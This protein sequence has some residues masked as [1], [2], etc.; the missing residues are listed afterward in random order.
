VVERTSDKGV[1]SVDLRPYVLAV[2]SDGDRVFLRIR[3]T[4][5]GTAKPEEALRALG[6]RI[7]EGVRIKKTYTEL[8]ARD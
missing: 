1:K 4:D 3:I 8:A 5:T 7:E 2:D 6:I